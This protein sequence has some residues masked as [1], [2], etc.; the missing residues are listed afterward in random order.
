MNYQEASDIRKK[1]FTQSMT[2]KLLA[3]QGIRQSFK[4]TLSEKTKARAVSFKQK[5][6]PLN[7]AKMLTF[8]SKLGPA[9]LGRMTGRSQEDI[10][11]FSGKKEKKSGDVG[12]LNK[13]I[14]FSGVA[15]EF[16]TEILGE[17]YK[18]LQKIEE[19]RKLYDELLQN[20]EEE[21]QSELEKRNQQ[22][23]KALTG[24]SLKSETRLDKAKKKKA[25]VKEK[26]QAK[27]ES[28]EIKSE[29]KP[30]STKPTKVETPT[31]T[32]PTT[33]TPA[34][35]KP[36]IPSVSSAGVGTAVKT[37]GAAAIVGGLLMPSETVAA[38]IDKASKEVG[39]EKPLMY[40]MAKQES[41]F[42]A[43]AAAKT[44]SAKGLYQFIKG[45]WKTMVEKYGSKYPILKERGPDDAEANA[46]AGALFI[47]ENSEYL[48][49]YNIPVNATTIYAAH[50]LGPGGAKTL[51]TANPNS[52]AAQL[53][54]A[55]AAANKFIFYD[56][57]TGQPRTVQQV[58][59]VLFEKVGKFETAYANK[60]GTPSSIASA[61]SS[62]QPKSTTLSS[63]SQENV[64]LRGD[65]NATKNKQTNNTTVANIQ[66][67]QTQSSVASVND[68][69]S[70][71]DKKKG[72][73]A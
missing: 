26:K 42:D 58:I 7:I 16:S 60:L 14:G 39:V 12:K 40:A 36:S 57:T 18:L 70:A 23:V 17:I 49:K 21:E 3:G 50:F 46:I 45:T 66:T 31:T 68:D 63:L 24:R 59:D 25:E 13:S 43:S 64:N 54:P 35:P 2:D 10:E 47:K 72:M 73:S 34:G 19:D 52:N 32:K 11:F 71:Y 8:G 38:A 51:L 69:R 33:T 29:G 27:R 65:M 62:G 1:G 48:K 20:K 55:P 56:K 9:L 30:V 28:K 37:A 67:N 22:I 4:S 61:S 41:G 15:V 44:S 5:F 6:D 53:M